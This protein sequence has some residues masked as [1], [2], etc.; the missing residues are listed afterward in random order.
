MELQSLKD[1]HSR[2]IE[3]LRQ[4]AQAAEDIALAPQV[5]AIE[6]NVVLA[7]KF[8]DNTS[9][10]KALQVTLG[11]LTLANAAAHLGVAEG[12]IRS[13]TKILPRSEQG[14]SGAWKVGEPC[15]HIIVEFRAR[16]TKFDLMKATNRKALETQPCAALSDKD[17]QGNITTPYHLCIKDHLL[18]VELAH[19][20]ELQSSAMDKL[21]GAQEHLPTRH[22]D[23]IAYSWRRSKITW[24]V[25]VDNQGCWALL[26]HLDVPPGASVEAVQE[27]AQ[28]AAERAKAEFRRRAP[29]QAR[30]QHTPASTSN[31]SA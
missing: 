30:R 18:G 23:R 13:F 1:Q 9:D 26:S 11:K 14:P 8:P 12:D 29:Q 19:K 21:Q 25:P 6:A 3:H 24:R 27:A 16:A 15:S 17:A 7:P 22:P 5:Q 4:G 10:T 28:R 2:A 20:R 31:A